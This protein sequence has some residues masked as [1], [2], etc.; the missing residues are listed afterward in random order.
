M[1]DE[2]Y[3]ATLDQPIGMLGNVTPR[4]AV[5]TKKGREKVVE[6]LKH[7]EIGS[8]GRADQDPMATYDFGWML[9]ELKVEDLRES[10]QACLFCCRQSRQRL[11]TACDDSRIVHEICPAPGLATALLVTIADAA[12]GNSEHMVRLPGSSR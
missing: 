6:W 5:K 4:A 1:L 11:L 12:V 7:L 8:A 10:T 2:H 9:R 3:R